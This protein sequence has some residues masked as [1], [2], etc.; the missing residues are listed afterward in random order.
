[1]LVIYPS[2]LFLMIPSSGCSK[3]HYAIL[4]VIRLDLSKLPPKLLVFLVVINLIV[5]PKWPL[6]TQ[7]VHQLV[8][9]TILFLEQILTP[10]NSKC[11]VYW[12]DC[13]VSP[14]QAIKVCC[15]ILH[16]HMSGSYAHRYHTVICAT[17]F[18]NHL[19][20]IY[21]SICVTIDMQLA[22]CNLAYYVGFLGY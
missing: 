20:G 11:Q 12:R 10:C 3:I 16:N 19:I 7:D 14:T 4:L 22:I 9:Y 1:M 17:T 8:A 6:T 15:P 13:H 18:V 2:A 21:L 5:H